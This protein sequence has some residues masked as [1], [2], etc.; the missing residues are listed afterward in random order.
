MRRRYGNKVVCAE[1][2]TGAV[3]HTNTDTDTET[4][5]FTDTDTHTGWKTWRCESGGPTGGEGK[6][7][8]HSSCTTS[9]TSCVS[10]SVALWTW[11]GREEGV[12]GAWEG[13]GRA[14]GREGGKEREKGREREGGSERRASDLQTWLR[15]TGNIARHRQACLDTTSCRSGTSEGWECVLCGVSTAIWLRGGT[16]GLLRGNRSHALALHSMAAASRGEDTPPGHE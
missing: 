14:R 10:G 3:T 7:V 11:H 12:R 16:P 4:D 9:I 5:T 6:E 1:G 8:A 13:G 2:R 15:R